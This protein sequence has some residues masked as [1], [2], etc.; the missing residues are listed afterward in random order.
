MRSAL[1]VNAVI[2]AF[3]QIRRLARWDQHGLNTSGRPVVGWIDELARFNPLCE[4]LYPTKVEI[5][6]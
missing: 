1:I 3:A 4:A 2:L 6:G 5:V